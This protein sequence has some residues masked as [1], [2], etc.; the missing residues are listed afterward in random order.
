MQRELCGTFSKKK[1]GGD[2]RGAKE[3]SAGAKDWCGEGVRCAGIALVLFA[4]P[5]LAHAQTPAAGRA[6][7]YVPDFAQIATYVFVM[8]GPVKIL[9]PFATMTRGM[10]G[11]SLRRLALIGIVVSLITLVAAATIGVST[12][13][14]W[15]I[16]QGALQLAGGAIIFLVALKP[17][18][19]QF[20]PQTPVPVE[21]E[22]KPAPLVPMKQLLRALVFP[23]IVTPQGLALIILIVAAYPAVEGDMALAVGAVMVLNLMI[24]LFARLI[25][26]TPGLGFALMIFGNVLGVLQVALGVQFIIGA[27]RVSGILPPLG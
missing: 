25:L 27:L 19:A 2:M 17:I 21:V 1:H 3:K 18:L 12:L 8:L 9:G 5:V 13:G 24:M 22:K 16:S 10:E 14:K 7:G 20:S 15:R 4:L 11:K 6:G 23:T 26:K